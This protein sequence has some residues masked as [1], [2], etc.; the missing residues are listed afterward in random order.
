MRSRVG[1]FAVDPNFLESCPTTLRLIYQ[2]SPPST[3]EE[4]PRPV[5]RSV[6]VNAGGTLF[7][8]YRYSW[9]GVTPV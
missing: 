8:L 1:S 5:L 7:D 6:W 4:K 2:F 3:A 9:R